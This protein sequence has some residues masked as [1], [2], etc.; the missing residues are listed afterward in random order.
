M[1]TY[2]D[3]EMTFALVTLMVIVIVGLVI[4]KHF[5]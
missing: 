5:V 1:K 2:G 3:T 4:Y